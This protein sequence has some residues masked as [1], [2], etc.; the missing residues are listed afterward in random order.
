MVNIMARSYEKSHPWLK[1]SV[2]ALQHDRSDV[3]AMLGECKSKCEH[4]AGVPLRPDVAKE[5][6][7]L[8]LAKGILATAAIEGNTLSEDEVRKILDGTLSLPPSKEYLSQEIK[9]IE[10]AC[11]DIVRRS[12]NHE[13][14]SLNVETFCALNSM[15]LKDLALDESVTPGA[16]RKHRVGVSRYLAA[17]PDDCSYLLTRLGEWL[18]GSDFSCPETLATEFAIIRAALAHLYLAWIHPFG[19]GNG[20]TARL[21]EFQILLRAGVPTPAAHLLSNHY[22][23]TRTE[24]YRQ[25]DY[26]SR[27]GGDIVPFVKYAVQGFRDGLSEQIARI[28][29]FQRDLTWQSIIH[30]AFQN[31]ERAGDKRKK[32]LVLDLSEH[33]KPIPIGDVPNLSA[34]CAREYAGKTRMTLRRDLNEL[35][36]MSLI[37]LTEDKRS[38]VA[39]KDLVDAFLPQRA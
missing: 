8:Y 18:D 21:V 33:E 34:R 28:R 1:F 9:N 22:N 32:H 27:S 24:Y 10:D 14:I 2:R 38:I 19:D 26:A 15:V 5:L 25:F 31:K 12:I 30:G 3:W 23:Q 39:N 29:V 16:I 17:P 35:L 37:T 7:Q 13:Q 11:R 36:S 20:R 4:I 6:H